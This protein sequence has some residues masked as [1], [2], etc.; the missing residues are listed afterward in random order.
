MNIRRS[1]R[2]LIAEDHNLVRQGYLYLIERCHG[3]IVVAEAK[4]GKEL[5]QQY[6]EHYPD[7]V[8]SDLQMPEIDGLEAL[9]KI[10]KTDKNAKFLFLTMHASNKYCRM[11]KA[12]GGKG[13]VS[14][15]ILEQEL[16]E[17]IKTVARGDEYFI[18]CENADENN[19]AKSVNDMDYELIKTLTAQEKRT[20]KYI[21]K[22][23]SRA[24]IA[25]LMHIGIRTIDTFIANIKL[26][27]NKKKLSEL[28]VIAAECDELLPY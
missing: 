19:M 18:T 14:K 27:L 23:N 16:C 26:K 17:A 10:K 1:I 24:E 6:R 13:M 12:V 3:I 5:I 25:D 8:V 11:I 22:G 9:E 28:S 21:G 15:R 2:I 20:L 7:V 4:N